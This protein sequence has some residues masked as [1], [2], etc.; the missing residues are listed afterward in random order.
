MGPPPQVERYDENEAFANHNRASPFE[1][2]ATAM[3][4]RIEGPRGVPPPGGTAAAQG[5]SVLP[6]HACSTMGSAFATP[7]PTRNVAD[8]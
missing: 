5:P 1:S 6:T 8:P 4:R 3:P 7:T 2:A